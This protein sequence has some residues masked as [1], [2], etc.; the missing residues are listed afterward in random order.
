[1]EVIILDGISK[2]WNYLLETRINMPGNSFAN[3]AKITSMQNTFIN[4]TLSSDA[5]IIATTR[6]KQDSVLNQKNGKMVPEKV[7]LKAI[8]RNDLD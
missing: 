1:M 6:V 3:W 2:I 7:G 5:H 4:K 8:Q